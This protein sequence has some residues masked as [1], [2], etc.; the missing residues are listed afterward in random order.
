MRTLPS[1]SFRGLKKVRLIKAPFFAWRWD[2]DRIFDVNRDGEINI[3]QH[4]GKPIIWATFDGI[5][6][7]NSCDCWEIVESNSK[8]KLPDWW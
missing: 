2:V 3:H 5:G 1:P 6:G 8:L 4:D 7:D